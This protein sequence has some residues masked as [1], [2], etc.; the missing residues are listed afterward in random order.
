M[1]GN[2]PWPAYTK[3]RMPNTMGTWLP[4]LGNLG[5]LVYLGYRIIST[6][7]LI[8]QGYNKTMDFSM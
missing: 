4:R 7:S 3:A 6:Y 1:E 2:T 8:L 5:I